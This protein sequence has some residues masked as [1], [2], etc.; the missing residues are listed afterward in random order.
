[1]QSEVCVTHSDDLTPLAGFN[2]STQWPE[3]NGYIPTY[4]EDDITGRLFKM[5]FEN[6]DLM[7]EG[8]ISNILSL[9]KLLR[10]G[11]EFHMTENGK[12]CYALTPGGAH[13]VGIKLGIDDILRIQHETRSSAERVPLPEQPGG[14]HAEAS[15][16][17][18][19]V[20]TVTK[21]A[22]NASSQFIHDCFF[23]RGDEKLYHTLGVTKGY[24]QS[25]I[26]TGH[27]DSCAKAK[28][29]EFGLSQQRIHAAFAES[30]SVFDDDNELD[31]ADS[32]PNEEEL[33]Y[34]SPNIGRKL[35]EQQVPRFDIGIATHL[36][37]SFIHTSVLEES[38]MSLQ[39]RNNHDE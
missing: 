6:V 29:R 25:N 21:T 13:R 3:G 12:S 5:D 32:E 9:G 16:T 8:L 24:T 30:D 33:E 38:E 23:H 10:N 27:C 18:H 20:H 31:P 2:G 22:S 28:A 4:M 34:V 14:A 1:M 36:T 15:C 37:A 19:P 39:N 11:W 35:G 7:T 17:M 26:V